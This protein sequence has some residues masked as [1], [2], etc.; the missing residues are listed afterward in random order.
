LAQLSGQPN[1]P[2]RVS[3]R[4]FIAAW[5]GPRVQLGADLR[6]GRMR[7]GL[8]AE[9]G[10]ALLRLHGRALGDTSTRWEGPWF[11]TALQAGADL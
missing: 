1:E 3:G 8:V 2:A 5:G 4:S 7:I 6:W 9:V 10:L 11:F